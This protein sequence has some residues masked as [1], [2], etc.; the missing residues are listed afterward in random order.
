MARTKEFEEKEVLEKAMQLFWI[1][2]YQGTSMEDLTIG[3]GISRS[4]LYDTFG[5]KRALFMRALQHYTQQARRGLNTIIAQDIS[6]KEK[7]HR[8]IKN[9]I[10]SFAND[11]DKKGCM[12]VNITTELGNQDEEIFAFTQANLEVVKD[13]FKIIFLEGQQDGSVS[14]QQSAEDLA[15]FLFNIYNGLQ[16]SGKMGASQEILWRMWEMAE[17]VF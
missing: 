7:I 3:L 15:Y 9:V 17:K 13:I 6:G 11:K 2:S 8:L 1:R 16:V 14:T 10:E 12:V 4:S 5:G